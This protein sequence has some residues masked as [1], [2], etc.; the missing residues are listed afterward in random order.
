MQVIAGEVTTVPMGAIRFNGPMAYD[1]Y[2]GGE[3]VASYNDPEVA[4]TAPPGTYTLTKYFDEDVVLA[5][6]VVVTAGAIT[7]VP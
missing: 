7:D 6:D 1:I 4:V 5:T 3:L 2:V